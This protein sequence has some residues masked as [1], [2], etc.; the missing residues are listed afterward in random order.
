MRASVRL[1]ATSAY[2]EYSGPCVQISNVTGG[3]GETKITANIGT[4]FSS[5]ANKLNQDVYSF[6][7]NLSWYLGNHTLTFGTHNEIYKIS[8]LFIQASEGA[9]TIT[10]WITSCK[11]SPTS[12]LQVQ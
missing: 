12:Y 2:T 6:E 11:T 4:E 7:D 9:G 1:S 8:N 10:L 5:G 3:D